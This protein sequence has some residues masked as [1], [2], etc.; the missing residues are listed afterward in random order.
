MVE[1]VNTNLGVPAQN[2]NFQNILSW[3]KPFSIVCQY[4]AV[5]QSQT[6]IRFSDIT[7]TRG[8]MRAQQVALCDSVRIY[9]SNFCI[10]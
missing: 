5:F 3:H 10:V 8:N 1:I 2:G 7:T 9:G 4:W 6:K